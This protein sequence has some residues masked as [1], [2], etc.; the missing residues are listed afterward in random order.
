MKAGLR[1]GMMAFAAGLLLG[2]P[3]LAQT[4]PQNTIQNSNP[5]TRPRSAPPTN[6]TQPAT[7]VGPRELQNFSLGGTV[8]SAGRDSAACDDGA[9]EPRFRTLCNCRAATAP[10]PGAARS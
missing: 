10:A 5:P 3:A 9:D 6:T 7:T 2:A 4:L 8:D 1:L